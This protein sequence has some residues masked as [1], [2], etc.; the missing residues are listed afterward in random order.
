MSELVPA[1]KPKPLYIAPDIP[2]AMDDPDSSESR[3]WRDM[4]RGRLKAWRKTV[5]EYRKHPRVFY[6]AYWLIQNHPVFYKFED[7]RLHE[8][9]L[10]AADGFRTGLRFEVSLADMRPYGF[11]DIETAV[12]TEIHVTGWPPFAATGRMYN[13]D[14]VAHGLDQAVVEAA[15]LVVDRFGFDRREL[16]AG[17]TAMRPLIEEP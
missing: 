4:Q 12:R 9:A 16:D 17:L 7:G 5:D 10:I 8:S 2:W 14:G 15:R 13:L 6:W 3:L 1:E 11:P